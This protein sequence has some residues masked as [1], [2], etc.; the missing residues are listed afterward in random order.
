MRKKKKV[1]GLVLGLF[2]VLPGMA[3]ANGTMS[4]TTN[5]GENSTE[6]RLDQRHYQMMDKNWQEKMKQKQQK[7]LS[8][9]NKYTPEKT[10]E[11]EAVIKDRNRIIEKWQSPQFAE[12]RQQWKKE[13]MA[14][15]EGLHKQYEE[16]KITKEEFVKKVHGGKETGHW[17]I[18]HELKDSVK[19][20]NH[21]RTAQLLNQLLTH[22]KK[23]NEIMNAAMKS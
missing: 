14:K 2:L 18:Y 13:K 21:K 7:L 1:I 5:K 22:Y 23:Q 9:V 11:W 4:N 6:N 15:F 16:G 20:N 17:K 19:N 12:K 10:Q 8:F 3:F